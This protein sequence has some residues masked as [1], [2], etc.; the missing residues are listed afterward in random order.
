[1]QKISRAP[2]QTELPKVV[3]TPHYVTKVFL[4]MVAVLLIANLTIIYL[5]FARGHHY[6]RVTDRSVL[7]RWRSKFPIT[8]FSPGNLIQRVPFVENR[9]APVG[10]GV[11]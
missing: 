11:A 9:N 1:M 8:L 4:G 7:F 6:L 5:K 3:I 10:G 2:L